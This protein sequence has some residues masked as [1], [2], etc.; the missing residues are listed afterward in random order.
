[1]ITLHKFNGDE[2]VL[3]ASQI[4]VIEKTPDTIITLMNDK[5]FIVKES[6]EEVINRSIDYYHRIHTGEKFNE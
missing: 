2:F 5:K 3:N 6:M 4:E 1:M